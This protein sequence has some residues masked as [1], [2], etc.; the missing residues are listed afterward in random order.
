MSKRSILAILGEGLEI[1]RNWAATHFLVFMVDL[2]T[3]MTPLGLSFS[4]PMCYSEH[5][6]VC[7]LSHL[8]PVWLSV[9]PWT[10]D[11]HAPLSTGFSRQ[12]HWSGL[13]FP[14]PGNLPDPGIKPASLASPAL[15]ANSSALSHRGSLH[16]AYTETQ[17][18][19]EV[20]S[21]AI[22]DLFGFNHLRHIYGYVTLLKIVPCPLP[23]CF[24]GSLVRNP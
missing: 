19:A 4:L 14:P 5:M 22:L 20:D 16:W 1:S 15:Q 13:P 8:S 11:H 21:P 17:D 23:S 10:S 18:V 6:G 7:T 3:V 9:T 24:R 2:G 12:E